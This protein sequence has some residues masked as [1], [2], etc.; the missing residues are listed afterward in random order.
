[1]REYDEHP[2]KVARARGS[3]PVEIHPEAAGADCTIWVPFDLDGTRWEGVLAR[4]LAPDRARVCA[5]PFWVYDLNFLDEVST[6]DSAEGEP[7]ATGRVRDAGNFT[8]RVAFEDAAEGDRRWHELMLELEPLDCWFDVRDPGY[9]A[10]SAAPE[11]AQ[12][13][14]DHLFDRESR[15]E[16]QYE[17]GRSG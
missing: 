7:V 12:A 3:G 14:A 9:L 6:A 16:L 15:G 11:R 13:V 17:T 2:S 8:Y 1:V 4:R 10:I 5:I